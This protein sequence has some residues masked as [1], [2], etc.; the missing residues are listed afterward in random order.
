MRGAGTS[1]RAIA[2]ALEAEGVRTPRQG[3]WT[4]VAARRVLE[5][6]GD[7]PWATGPSVAGTGAVRGFPDPHQRLAHGGQGHG[8]E[9]PS[10]GLVVDQE[11]VL[12]PVHAP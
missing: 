10:G 8:P 5:G 9:P 12:R 3:R 7:G 4:A 1:L 6:G 11:T 2:A